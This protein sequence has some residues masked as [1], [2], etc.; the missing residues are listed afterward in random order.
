MNDALALILVALIGQTGII[1]PLLWSTRRH[2]KEA[3][4]AVNCKP[5]SAPRI[6]EVVDTTAADVA[7]I[8]AN[9]T[10]IRSELVDIRAEQDAIRGEVREVRSEQ[11][12][13][14]VTLGE[15]QRATD[16]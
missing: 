14:A 10:E 7:K 15:R 4:E 6:S 1:A 9:L 5:K 16:E 11:A 3:N 8:A 12:F 13:V 2:A